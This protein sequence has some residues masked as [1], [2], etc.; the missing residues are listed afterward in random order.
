MR[1]LLDGGLNMLPTPRA[2]R[3]GNAK[4]P[5]RAPLPGSPTV[6]PVALPAADEEALPVAPPPLPLTWASSMVLVIA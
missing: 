4:N 3:E 6:L 5:R 2:K 1:S